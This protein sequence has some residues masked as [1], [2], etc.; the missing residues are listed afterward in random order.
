M[1]TARRGDGELGMRLEEEM[2][3]L[4]ARIDGREGN[5]NGRKDTAGSYKLI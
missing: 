1:I 4:G 5:V 3:V 2:G